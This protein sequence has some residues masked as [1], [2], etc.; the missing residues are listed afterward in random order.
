[1]ILRTSVASVS[2]KLV[3]KLRFLYSPVYRNV[4]LLRETFLS[5]CLSVCGYCFI[6]EPFC[7]KG[8]IILTNFKNMSH[9]HSLDL[10]PVSWEIWFK[11]LC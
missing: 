5:L 8:L 9:K 3:S 6:C 11:N 2:S 4:F 1:M 10:M 7:R